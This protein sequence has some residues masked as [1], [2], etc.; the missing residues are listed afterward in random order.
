MPHPPFISI[1]IPA[2]GRAHLLRKLFD[3][4]AAQTFMDYNIVLTD[5]SPDNS[6]SLLCEEYASRL[7]LSYHKNERFL[8]MGGNWNACM[9]KGDGQ[10][11]KMMHDDD[12]FTDSESLGQFAAEA[13]KHEKGFIF[14]G[15]YNVPNGS[16]EGTK[17]LRKSI[18]LFFLKGSAFNLLRGNYIGAPSVTMIHRSTFRPFNPDLKWRVDTEGLMRMFQL[19]HGVFYIA[20]PLICV[21]IHAGQATTKLFQNPEVEIFE[22]CVML[23]PQYPQFCR[24]WFAYDHC[25]RLLRNL[26]IRDEAS[27]NKYARG[28][29]IP[30]V[31]KSII[32]F[33]K[34]VPPFILKNGLFSKGLMLLN[35]IYY[36]TKLMFC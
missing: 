20:E 3:S 1:C 28:A 26:G 10:W 4:I 2:Y 27:L 30:P 8:E 16:E 19:R 25:W 35:F 22:N 5:N 23:A 32:R 18:D 33:Q 31:F 14:S 13:R 34:S 11:L 36:N 29:E 9:E 24:N 17:Y 12:W 21:G 15:F 6:V 7:P